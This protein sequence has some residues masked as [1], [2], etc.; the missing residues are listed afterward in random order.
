MTTN[1]GQT[2][3]T[4]IAVALVA[5]ILA[6]LAGACG[7]DDEADET[8]T[9]TDGTTG[10]TADDDS[11]TSSGTDPSSSSSGSTTSS[12][13]TT[14]GS[15][16]L[17]GEPID[18]LPQDGDTLGVLGVAHDDVLNVRVIP[19]ADTEIVATAGPTDDDLVST[20]VARKLPTT[21]WYQVEVDG[22]TGWINSSFVGFVGATD[23]ATAEFLEGRERPETETME[24]LGE[25]VAEAFASTDPASRI[26]Q[27]VAP[28]VGDLGEVT[29]DVV[30]LGDDSL[31]G[32][33]LHVFAQPGEG[34]DSFGL[35]S[36][37]R[38]VFCFRGLA[39]ELCV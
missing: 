12:S 38:T 23:D 21:I 18:S 26:V 15:T 28:T 39:G 6:L 30:G 22:V 2:K 36:I 33:R 4:A 7:G 24:E 37:E 10:T 16:T 14:N 35:T 27:S 20:G 3:R 17:P 29:Y 31:L 32:Y 5:L 25:L 9:T 34:G 11:T 8:T 13:T 1:G 19:G